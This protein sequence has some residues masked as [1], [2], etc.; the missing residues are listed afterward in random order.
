MNA[1]NVNRKNVL[2]GLDGVYNETVHKKL[3]AIIHNISANKVRTNPNILLDDLKQETWMRIFE[4]I[5]KNLKKGI[6]LEISYLVAVA[7][8]TTLGQC[9]KESKRLS[10]VDEF[11]SMLMSAS[12]IAVDDNC[13]QHLN[14]AKAKLEYE[15]QLQKPDEETS[16]ILRLSLEDLLESL[17]DELIKNLIIITY[18]KKCNGTSR[19]I[20][21]MYS[22]FVNTLDDDKRNILDNMDKFTY[23]DAFKALGMRATDNSSTR[24]R[25]EMRELLLTLR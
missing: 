2:L 9:Q 10:Q 1:T 25:K 4:V 15:L 7:Q 23:N 19:K 11:S 18:I 20:L 21:N 5:N 14:V 3:N 24:I 16:T 6:E 8:T 12:D 22:T 13:R 17:E